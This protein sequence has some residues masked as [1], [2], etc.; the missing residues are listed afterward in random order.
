MR[1]CRSIAL[2][3]A[4]RLRHPL[5]GTLRRCRHLGYTRNLRHI[6]SFG[7]LRHRRL[8]RQEIGDV[9]FRL[10]DR[11]SLDRDSRRH[12]SRR[13]VDAGKLGQLLF[14]CGRVSVRSERTGAHHGLVYLGHLLWAG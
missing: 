13:L 14:G 7:D 4:L 9:R 2:H 12:V 3:D 1:R 8:L 6:G 5:L 11:R 10:C